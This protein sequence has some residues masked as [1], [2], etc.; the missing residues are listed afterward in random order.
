MSEK[1]CALR[2]KG[3]GGQKYTE[4]SLWTNSSPSSD[5]AAQ[6]V[7]LSDSID[8]YKYI[9]IKYVFSSSYNTGNYLSDYIISV[10]DLKKVVYPETSGTARL[11]Y[12]IARVNTSNTASYRT[13]YYVSNDSI[14]FGSAPTS[15]LTPLEILGLNEL[16]HGKRFDETT[17]WTN[18]AP[19]NTFVNQTVSLSDDIDNYDYIKVICRVSTSDATEIKALYSVSDFK[20]YTASKVWG[21]STC[22]VSS[23]LYSRLYYYSSDTAL[24]FGHTWKYASGSGT[25]GDGYV[26]PTSIVGCKFA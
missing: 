11:N 9:K 3:G 22:Q 2:K 26:I 19:T 16:D 7:T 24:V 6:T 17:L 23:Y 18:N 12:T 21:S 13:F 8:N 14:R 20:T 10:D 5:F 15:S 1:L 25:T 4:T